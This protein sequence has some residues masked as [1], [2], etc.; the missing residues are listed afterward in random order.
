VEF[1]KELTPWFSWIKKHYEQGTLEGILGEAGSTVLSIMKTIGFE[2][3]SVVN[4]DWLDAYTAQFP[5]RDSCKAV[6]EF[7]LDVILG[8]IKKYIVEGL[9]T[10]NLEKL[11]KKPA[12]LAF[13][14]KDKAFNSEYAIA[15]FKAIFPK[16]P[17]TTFENAS[18]FCQEDIPH[19]LIPLIE[20]FLQI[21]E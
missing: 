14:L 5:D 16:A 8:R 15:D 2:N 10:G 21:T 1:S 19:I 7:P 12:M 3:S 9:K 13:G 4:Q 17:I 11:R 6:I 20:Q 18:H